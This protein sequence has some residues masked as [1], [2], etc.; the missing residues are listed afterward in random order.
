[1]IKF[2][3]SVILCILYIIILIFEDCKFVITYYFVL[4]YFMYIF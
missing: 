4:Y 1:M 3:Y 2:F